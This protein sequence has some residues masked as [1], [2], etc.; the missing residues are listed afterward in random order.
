MINWGHGITIV[1]IAFLIG[2]LGMV[3]V[4]SQQTNDMMDKDYYAQ[5]LKYQSIIDATQNLNEVFKLPLIQTAQGQVQ[6]A[7][8]P[9]LC[10]HITNGKVELIKPNDK[11]KDRILNLQP[12]TSGKQIIDQ[13]LLSNGYYR[14][15]IYWENNNIPY[16]H[17]QEIRV[18]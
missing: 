5:E 7:I 15:R 12:D 2:M 6:L 17:E 4:A 1:I 14:A 11:S 9:S 8:P 18:N 3:Y 13:A 16:Y 10:S